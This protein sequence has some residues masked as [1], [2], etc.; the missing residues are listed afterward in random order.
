MVDSNN[1]VTPPK[2]CK[3]QNNKISS[4]VVRKHRYNLRPRPVQTY[5]FGMME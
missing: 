5:Y 3:K 1:K 4:I 2:V